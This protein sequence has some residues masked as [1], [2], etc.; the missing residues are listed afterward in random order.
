MMSLT[1]IKKFFKAPKVS[2]IDKILPNQVHGKQT[3]R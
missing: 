3:K 1:F 2:H